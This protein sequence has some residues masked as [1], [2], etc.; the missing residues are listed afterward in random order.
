MCVGGRSEKES[1]CELKTSKNVP[2]AY[3]PGEVCSLLF[4]VS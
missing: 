2:V 3:Y 1:V 4:C